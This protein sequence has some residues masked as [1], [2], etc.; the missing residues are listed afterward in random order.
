MDVLGKRYEWGLL[1][2]LTGKFDVQAIL[3]PAL[4]AMAEAQAARAQLEAAAKQDA[5]EER[6]SAVKSSPVLSEIIEQIVIDEPKTVAEFKSGK[7]KA[8]NALVGKVIGQIRQR[9]LTADVTGDAF[10][11]NQLLRQRLA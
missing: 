4:A 1:D 8:L 3:K 10:A 11:I 9:K 2:E 7:E 6:A 5:L